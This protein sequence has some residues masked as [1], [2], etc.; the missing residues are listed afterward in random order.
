MM[1]ACLLITLATQAAAF[2]VV[3]AP[4]TTLHHAHVAAPRFADPL[5]MGIGKR[6]GGLKNRVTGLLGKASSVANKIDLSSGKA[7]LSTRMSSEMAKISD[8]ALST[9]I[10][11][12][13]GF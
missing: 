5:E 2:T 11:N 10:R 8:W 7:D 9:G 3:V 13:I 1:R 4:P 12:I 6:L